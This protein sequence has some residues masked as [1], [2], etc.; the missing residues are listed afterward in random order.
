MEHSA[1]GLTPEEALK[2]ENTALVKGR[3]EVKALRA[4]KYP[5]INRGDYVKWMQK[6]DKLDKEG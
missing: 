2:P 6:R 4:R 5:D 1:T 3:L